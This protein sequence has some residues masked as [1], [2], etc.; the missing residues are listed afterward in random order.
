[1][2]EREPETAAGG[3]PTPMPP[4]LH[5]SARRLQGNA[6]VPHPLLITPRPARSDLGGVGAGGAHLLRLDNRLHP[7]Q[8]LGDGGADDQV[9][10][11][12]PLADFLA[13]HAQPL[14]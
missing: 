14:L 9:I 11:I 3:F 1:M 13:R 6:S 5:R 12:L 7:P 8:I 4:P 2:A 10:E